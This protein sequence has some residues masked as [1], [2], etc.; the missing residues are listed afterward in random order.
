MSQQV[1]LILIAIVAAVAANSYNYKK[2]H[3]YYV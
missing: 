2:Q 1:A 3:E